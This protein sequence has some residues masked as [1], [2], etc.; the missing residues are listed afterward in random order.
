V[1]D[2]LKADGMPPERVVIVVKNLAN[3]VGIQWNNESLF[4]DLIG[5]CIHRYFR[6]PRAD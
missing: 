3:D 6:L 2:A 1:V 5:W 4:D